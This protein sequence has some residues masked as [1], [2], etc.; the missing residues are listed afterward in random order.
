MGK[1]IR[2]SR[3]ME[4]IDDYFMMEMQNLEDEEEE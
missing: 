3:M 2:G 4:D 1:K